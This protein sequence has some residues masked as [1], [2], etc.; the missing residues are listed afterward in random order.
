MLVRSKI[1]N[2]CKIAID[3]HI[4]REA[5]L[6]DT[7]EKIPE[8]ISSSSK[9]K[10]LAS[11]QNINL[12]EKEVAACRKWIFHNKT[13]PPQNKYGVQSSIK[14]S[15]I[16]HNLEGWTLSHQIETSSEV[17]GTGKMPR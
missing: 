4:N 1:R 8:D 6:E 16:E 17:F 10:A 9:R 3:V 11:H 5:P 2:K 7:P 13:F 15:I 14:Q 12:A